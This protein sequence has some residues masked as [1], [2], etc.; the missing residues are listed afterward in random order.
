MGRS[1]LVA[2]FLAV[3][4][5][6]VTRSQALAEAKLAYAKQD[7]VRALQKA[8]DHLGRRPWDREAQL[9][10]ARCYSQLDFADDAEPYY[11]RAGPLSLDDLQVRALALVR[12]NLRERAVQAYREILARWPDDV[13]ALRRLAAVRLSQNGNRNLNDELVELAE[14]LIKVPGGAAVGFTLKGVV[15]HN[16]DSPETAVIN[17]ERVLELDPELRVMPLPKREFWSY[18]A[19][20]LLAIGRSA[21]VRRYLLRATQQSPDSVLLNQLGSAYQQEGAID[22]A[23]RCWR[24]AIERDPR[25]SAPLLNLGRLD[26]QRNRLDDALKHLNQALELAPDGRETVYVLSQVYRR[27]GRM[28]DA[29]RL[30]KDSEEKRRKRLSLPGDPK[31]VPGY[32]L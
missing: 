21:D 5:W 9:L 20:D 16:D 22:E 28:A 12:S 8:L 25:Y 27:L 23:E 18:L 13:T 1:I 15:Y 11:R 31:V 7:V 24:Q 29:E 26:L 3:T 4:A 32:S 2:C 19:S 30:L 17:L 6:N 14:R 10:A